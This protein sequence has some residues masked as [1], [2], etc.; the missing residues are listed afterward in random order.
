MTET[1][2]TLVV[3]GASRGIGRACVT[4]ALSRDARVRAVARKPEALRLE[5][6]DLETFAAD[7]TDAEALAPALVGADAVLLTLG[8]P[9]NTQTVLRPVHLFSEATAA[10]IAA[11]GTAGCRRLLAVT[12]FGTSESREAVTVLEGVAFQGIM[13][14]VYDDKTRQEALIRESGLDWTIARPVI[15]TNGRSEGRYK[16]LTRPE[17]WRNGLIPRAEVAHF[18]IGAALDGTYIGDAPVLAR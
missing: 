1:A 15:L 9:L 12:G 13:G 8:V 3:I 16:V 11:M 18:L 6:P 2:K 7:A 14:R 17:T 10:V 5:H 4:T